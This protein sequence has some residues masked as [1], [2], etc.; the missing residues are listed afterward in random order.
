[1]ATFKDVE[2]RLSPNSG[3]KNLGAYDL[4]KKLEKIYSH[5]DFSP[6][7]T[8]RKSLLNNNSP[9]NS[10]LASRVLLSPVARKETITNQYNFKDLKNPFCRVDLTLQSLK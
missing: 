9:K 1:M 6:I 8:S 2:S 3:F 7:V 5:V 10:Q 4:T